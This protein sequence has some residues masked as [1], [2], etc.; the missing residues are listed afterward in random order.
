ME[1]ECFAAVQRDQLAAAASTIGRTES[2]SACMRAWACSGVSVLAQ[3]ARV[4]AATAAVQRVM[5]TTTSG[6]GAAAKIAVGVAVGYD[7]ATE[8]DVR[9]AV[10]TVAL[11]MAV[12]LSAQEPPAPTAFTARRLAMVELIAARRVTHT[13]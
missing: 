7:S 11:V 4:S 13:P 9:G 6:R 2:A 5:R 12:E 3:A 8:R 10:A 1:S